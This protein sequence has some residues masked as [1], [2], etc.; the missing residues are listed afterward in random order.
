MICAREGC[1]VKF[2]PEVH[3]QKYHDQK[4]KRRAESDRKRVGLYVATGFE[5]QW[6]LEEL[7]KESRAMLSAAKNEWI[8]ANKSFAMFDIEATHLDADFGRLI[9][10]CIKPLGEKPVSFSTLRGDKK[11]AEQIRDE[12]HKYDYIVT[13]YGTGYDVPFLATRLMKN[14]LDS[15]G[16]TR[17]VDMYYTA[18]RNLKLAS[19]RQAQVVKSLT[20]K[21]LRTDVIGTTWME[22]MEGDKKAVDYIVKHCVA[23]VYDLEEVF[24]WLV[25]FRN[26]GATP[27]R[28][29]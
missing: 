2:E 1:N 6:E 26:L 7:R 3:N 11:I 5:E 24:N 14:G 22:A 19:N 12:L 9:C 16:L 29:Y 20:K 28:N 8:L 27:L 10:A 18:R 17:Q 13:Y 25:R 21:V 23:D 15:L 4:C